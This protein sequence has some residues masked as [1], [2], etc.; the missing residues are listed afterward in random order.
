M[1]PCWPL[2]NR[3]ESTLICSGP[4]FLPSR[5]I[6][7]IL[8]MIRFWLLW[9]TT[10]G[11]QLTYVFHL[12]ILFIGD[13]PGFGKR[14]I[15]GNLKI[16]KYL[17]EIRSPKYLGDV[18]NWDIY[19]PLFAIFDLW[20]PIAL[21]LVVRLMREPEDKETISMHRLGWIFGDFFGAKTCGFD[22]F[23]SFVL[24]LS[25]T[26]NSSTCETWP[27]ELR[28]G[29]MIIWVNFK[30]IESHPSRNGCLSFKPSPDSAI[31]LW[32][33]WWNI[34]STM[35]YVICSSFRIRDS[36]VSQI[37]TCWVY[38]HRWFSRSGM[39]NVHHRLAEDSQR[40]PRWD[41]MFRWFK[42]GNDGEQ[43]GYAKQTIQGVISCH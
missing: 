21:Q 13:L 16:I 8:I 43:R 42:G 11:C 14:P 1:G 39:V 10:V 20:Y 41:G 38:Q 36:S 18:K 3:D 40:I 17:L 27:L 6:H 32:G 23:W 5:W 28:I 35:G 15:L 19:Q 30:R 34:W 7:S 22:T 33:F 24:W 37:T 25:D 31:K 2:R 12:N 9:S 29:S 4:R 26:C